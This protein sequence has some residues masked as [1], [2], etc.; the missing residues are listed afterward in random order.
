[1]SAVAARSSESLFQIK[2]DPWV[3]RFALWARDRIGGLIVRSKLRAALREYWDG[4]R[5]LPV[6]DTPRRLADGR[7]AWMVR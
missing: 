2:V 4:G 3:H 1:M 6:L 5:G 7:V